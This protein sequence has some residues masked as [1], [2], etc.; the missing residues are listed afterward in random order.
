M[1]AVVH[2]CSGTNVRAVL[3]IASGVDF[4][5]VLEDEGGM[6]CF[7]CSWVLFLGC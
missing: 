7:C 5:L 6:D 1:E 4:G 2:P 3:R